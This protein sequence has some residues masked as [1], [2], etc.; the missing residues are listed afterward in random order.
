MKCGWTCLFPFN[1]WC[2]NHF[3]LY[4]DLAR[5]KSEALD[6]IYSLL[7]QNIKSCKLMLSHEGNRNGEKTI[8]L[9]N[10]QKNNYAGAIT[11]FCT[12][13]CCCCAQQQYEASRK[14]LHVVAH[15]REDMPYMLLF[16]FFSLLLIFTLVATGISH[17]LTTATKFSC[18]CWNIKMSPLIF[19]S[20]S[21]S[22]S[23]FFSLSFA[24]LSPAFS[25]S[26]SFSFSILQICWH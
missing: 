13:L 8:G 5:S 21:S 25:F 26:L 18:C 10:Y 2:W 14:F 1:D 11:Y 23:L 16:T 22:L 20:C 17:F 6:N 15:F 24:G 19:I 3:H 4:I 7:K 9:V 12:F